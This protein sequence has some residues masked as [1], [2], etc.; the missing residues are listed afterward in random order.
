M[1]SALVSIP[2]D[3]ALLASLFALRE[4]RPRM[5]PVLQDQPVLIQAVGRPHAHAH[6]QLF[7]VGIVECLERL[8]LGESLRRLPDARGAAERPVL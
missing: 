6:E 5:R 8:S 1:S 4:W 2:A 7:V 3:S